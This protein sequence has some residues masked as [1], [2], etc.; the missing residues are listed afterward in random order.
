[1][2]GCRAVDQHH[3]R[4]DGAGYPLG[5]AAEDIH[6]SGRIVAVADAFDVI[7][8]ARSYKK[9][10]PPTLGREEIARCSGSQFDP[11]VVR[12]FLNIGLG[13]LR[14]AAGP[15][16]W[17]N[18]LPSVAD[19]AIAPALGPVASGVAAAAIAGAAGVTGWLPADDIVIPAPVGVASIRSDVDLTADDASVEL[20]EAAS[21]EFALGGATDGTVVVTI[22]EPPTNGTAAIV[23]APG[24]AGDTWRQTV[25]YTPAEGFSGGDRLV[26]E[27]CEAD[28]CIRGTIEFVIRPAAP[29]PP[30]PG[31]DIVAGVEDVA[32][33][34]AFADLLA[35][36]TDPNRDAL[37]IVAVEAG[38]DLA[39]TVGDDG[40]GYEPPPDH[41]GPMGLTYEVCDPGALCATA[42]V[43]LDLA[44]APDV[45]EATDDRFDGVE[46]R[47][48]T[49]TAAAVLAN[50]DDP[51]GE[52]LVVAR[53]GPATNVEAML[54]GTVIRYT[55]DPDF[56]GPA[57]IR[58]SVCDPT[59][60]CAIGTVTI[61]I[62]PAANAA[63]VAVGD[64]GVGFRV[65]EDTTLVTPDVTANDTDVDSPVLASSAR[66]A[67]PP[68]HGTATANGDGTFTYVPAANFFGADLFTYTITDDEDATSIAASIRLVVDPVNDAPVAADDQGAGFT[69]DEDTPFTTAS[70]IA[71]DLDV[72][73]P[74]DPTAITVVAP[75]TLGT[76]TPNGDGTVDY[77]PD[78]DAA[79]T[80]VFTY[81]LTDAAGTVSAP[82][83]VTIIVGSIDDA[84][85]AEDDGGAGYTTMEDTP[86]TTP[87]ATTNDTDPDDPIDPATIVVVAG[88]A[89]G[90]ATPNP[91]GTF[92]Y[93]PAAEFVGTDSWTYRVTDP[94]GLASAPATVSVSVV[95][96]N[97]AP[98]FTAGADQVV[99]EDAGTQTVVDWATG[100]S[101]GP[102]D[103]GGQALTFSTTNDNPALFATEPTVSPTGTLTFTP[104]ADTSGAATVT[105][106][107]TDDG[108][109]ANGGTDATPTTTFTIT[110]DPAND[111]PLFMAGADQTVAE[112]S[113]AHT[114][115]GWA[116]AIAPGP[117]D[118]AAQT[119]AFAVTNDNNG[120]FAAQPAVGP[121]GTLTYTPADDANGAAIVT[122]VL[123]DDGGT[124]DGGADTSAA[125]T[126]TITVDPVNDAP[127]F[128]KGPD[129]VVANNSGSFTA[130]GW[131]TT[132]GPGPAD[133]AAQNVAFTVGNDAN[134]LFTAQPAIG[135]TG[136]LTLTP[137]VGTSGT[138]TVTVELVDDG[139]TADGGSDTSPGQTFT[140]TVTGPTDRDGVAQPGSTTAR[141]PSTRSRSTPMATASATNATRR[142][143]RR[144]A[145]PSAT[146]ARR[147]EVPSR[148]RRWS[149]TSTGTA[150]S[151]VIF[152]NDTDDSTVYRRTFLGPLVNTGQSL[153]TD[154]SAGAALGDLDGDGDLDLVLANRSSTAN[155]LWFNDGSGTF[156]VAAQSLG[157]ASSEEVVVGDF[158][159]DGDLDLAFA[160]DNE[161][162][163]IWLN[164]GSGTFG[165]SGQALGTDPS[166]GVAVADIDGDTD[167]DL[168]FANNNTADRV[169]VNDGSG[170]F[171]DS[172]Q[173]LSATKSYAVALADVD[174]DT[175]A[176]IVVAA[177]NDPSTVWLNDGTGTFADSGQTI[178]PLHN[179][180][181]ALGDLDGDGDLDIAFAAHSGDNTVWL[182]D[183]AGVFTDSGQTIPSD[184]TED[185]ALAD[186]DRD[187]DLGLVF[188]NDG[189]ANTVW[190]NS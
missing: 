140:V 85:I 190:T 182:N 121:T 34:I 170:V 122:V 15:L 117:A 61:D 86:F 22:V 24:T 28:E 156:T 118:E 145:R 19:R 167:L 119:V 186:L 13:R 116:T 12:A 53:V 183:G 79:G 138:A 108:G 134:G 137:A 10:L 127:S 141:R 57:T 164:D 187:G 56:T 155:T 94:G 93:T 89:H 69:T 180:D 59:S 98:T 129:V 27:V 103:E 131:A 135:P 115:A 112:D 2:T 5:L 143:P 81:T 20:D 6:L 114:V 101:A 148:W 36:D 47:A 76:V 168:V 29:Q 171:T 66:V 91:D 92:D 84:P 113:G 31:D 52:D 110:V 50:D 62:A 77:T 106:A 48:G 125:Q 63:P 162:N 163:T 146:P 139:G 73:E 174:G 45:P 152:A 147:S 169:Y 144:R 3:E 72:D 124:A 165:S 35:N 189:G 102:T 74:I 25:S 177:D 130:A 38:P 67:A 8:S 43:T 128:T 149:A 88:P 150:T 153:G 60:R 175:D 55:P 68:S 111:A 42:R 30:V 46:N 123:T 151:I 179:R 7:T 178:G 78:P 70:L 14:L 158:D 23:G 33:T 126:F 11:D 71:N 64:S 157:T 16:A 32:D 9:G 51:D 176:D 188:A 161:P 83:V 18:A 142:R 120:L 173:L 160:N 17:L 132:I 181:L 80:D 172:G 96:V 133:E 136:T 87:S 107:L 4:W 40:I 39:I 37:S 65:A 26:Y 44:P 21:V 166:I 41:H 95:A 82:A 54:D 1:M 49:I 75:P 159:A 184:N 154:K 100:I 104:A 99:V 105:V 97:D 109:T 58:Y 185:V 90:A